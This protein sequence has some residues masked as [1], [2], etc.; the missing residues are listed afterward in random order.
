MSP[1]Y[2]LIF[3]PAA[4]AGPPG[5]PSLGRAHGMTIILI[6]YKEG[7][8]GGC[9][10]GNL[11]R[12]KHTE[13]R[14]QCKQGKHNNKV[15]VEQLFCRLW[16][17]L[18]DCSLSRAPWWY[19]VGQRGVRYCNDSPLLF[20][21]KGPHISLIPGFNNIPHYCVCVCITADIT[22]CP[23]PPVSGP[24]ANTWA[25]PRCTPKI[26]SAIPSER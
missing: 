18:T 25:R 20:Y 10:V 14:G 15:F 19:G 5:P 2:R 8:K 16:K 21:F 24:H 1:T 13:R 12:L 17:Y 3:F 26:I 22:C 23:T 7:S 11:P 4:A 9:G 6:G